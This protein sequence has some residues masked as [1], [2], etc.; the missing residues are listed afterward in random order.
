MGK[1][2]A[3]LAA[4]R[5][6]TNLTDPKVWKVRQNLIN[7]LIGLIGAIAVFLPET[8]GMSDE[9]ILSIAGGIATIA[10]LFNVYITT[11]TTDKIGVSDKRK[12]DP[13][14]NP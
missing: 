12:I 2:F 1:L 7:A 3:F 10:G 13:D 11:A 5:H 8:I 9:D 14:N 6:G 4:L